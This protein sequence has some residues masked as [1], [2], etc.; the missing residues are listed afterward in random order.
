MS[1]DGKKILQIRPLK[2]LKTK[3]NE[4]KQSLLAQ[5]KFNITAVCS[6]CLARCVLC[7][8]E[9]SLFGQLTCRTEILSCRCAHRWAAFRWWFCQRLVLWTCTSSSWCPGCGS[10]QL[11]ENSTLKR[12]L[13]R[14]ERATILVFKFESYLEPKDPLNLVTVTTTNA[15]SWVS[16][17]SRTAVECVLSF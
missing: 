11:T 17:S 1:V 3:Q 4:M 10:G 8:E 16:I 9:V 14:G 13:W 7:S 6:V 2:L 5:R 12:K 15:D